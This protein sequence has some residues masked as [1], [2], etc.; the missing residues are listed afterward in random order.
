MTNVHQYWIYIL[1]NSI[2]SV[3]YIG[4]TNDLYRRYME[5]QQ[6]LIDGFTK[7]YKC[8]S[9]LYYEEFNQIEE[10]IARE[11][12]LKGWNRKKKEELIRCQNPFF[13]D[14]AEP[15]GWTDTNPSA[16]L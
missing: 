12:Q 4:V 11:K 3:L 5:H 13:K 8:H 2:R 15:M 7:K 14:L 1:S 10:A 16:K 6:G 9:L